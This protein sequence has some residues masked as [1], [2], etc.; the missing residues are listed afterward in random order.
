MLG[1]CSQA[2]TKPFAESRS[3]RSSS[4]TTRIAG[5]RGQIDD[6]VPALAS[7]AAWP[8]LLPSS[9]G[10]HE[11][12]NTSIIIPVVLCTIVYNTK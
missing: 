1:G 4:R 12:Y 9:Y 5:D 2:Y 6:D 8:L 3:D 7:P 10:Q 11:H